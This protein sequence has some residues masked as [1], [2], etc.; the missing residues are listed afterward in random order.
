MLRFDD[1]AP[2]GCAA[3]LELCK[4]KVSPSD[5]ETL[6]KALDGERSGHPFLKKWQTFYQMTKAELND[7]RSRKLSRQTARYRNDGP[8]EHR[9]TE[10]VR[11]AVGSDNPLEGELALLQLFWKYL[12]ELA[13]LHTFDLEGLLC[14]ALKLQLL[15][16]KGL[17]DREDG[18]AEFKRLFSNLQT[19]IEKI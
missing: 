19:E 16:R 8:R 3:F 6:S 9:I 17:F 14:Y 11:V 2:F 1:A 7:Q 15:E 4:G 13:V 12:D 5:Y 10:T 18:N